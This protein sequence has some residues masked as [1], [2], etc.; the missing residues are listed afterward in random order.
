MIPPP[1]D[2]ELAQLIARVQRLPDGRVDISRDELLTI[3]AMLF[4]AWQWTLALRVKAGERDLA[5]AVTSTLVVYG[6]KGMGKTNLGR[7]CSSRSSRRTSALR[8]HRPDGRVWWGLRPRR[9]TARAASVSR[10][11]IL[12]GIHGDIPIEPTSGALVADLVVDEDDSVIIDI[13]R[14]ATARCGRS[15]SA[16][17]S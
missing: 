11:L 1:N 6:G 16:S 15:P 9:P 4:H 7:A 13:S 2:A 10:S 5:H 3:L 8:R 14:R 12:G 17:G